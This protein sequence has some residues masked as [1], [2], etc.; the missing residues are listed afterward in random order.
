MRDSELR[1]AA[2]ANGVS[3][4]YRM[5]SGRWHQVEPETLAAVLEAMGVDPCARR[6]RAASPPVLVA[7]RGRAGA[8]PPAGSTVVLESGERLP[9][10]GPV[11]IHI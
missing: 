11:S 9:A 1:R 7:R 5:V 4:S 6:D 3:T 8:P 10:P 2:K